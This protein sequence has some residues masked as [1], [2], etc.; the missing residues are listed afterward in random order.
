[1]ETVDNTYQIGSE[2]HCQYKRVKHE[3]KSG[4]ASSSVTKCVTMSGELR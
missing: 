3:C 1:M 2:K 4:V